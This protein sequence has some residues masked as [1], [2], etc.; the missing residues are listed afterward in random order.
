MPE[1][2]NNENSKSFADEADLLRNDSTVSLFE[3]DL[4]E[5]E[6]EALLARYHFL[7]IVNGKAEYSKMTSGSVFTADTGW[8][9]HD[10]TEA[11]STSPGDLILQHNTLAFD[12]EGNVI[13]EDEEGSTTGDEDPTKRGKGTL[14]LQAYLTAQ[15]LVKQAAERG[16]G[17]VII[18]NGDPYMQRS[19]WMACE[20]NGLAYGG[21]KPSDEDWKH[22][23]RVIR[24]E[25]EIDAVRASMGN[26]N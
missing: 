3:R 24:S 20:D 2:T 14:F 19:A 8:E 17:G 10:F 25:S 11:M 15:Q 5:Q 26:R 6:I 12:A 1:Q 9:V 13:E 16:W 7:Q 21:F 23:D 22:Y 4:H 18:A